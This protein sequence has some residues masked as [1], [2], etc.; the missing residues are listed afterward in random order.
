MRQLDDTHDLMPELQKAS[1]SESDDLDELRT[2]A[3][4]RRHTALKPDFALSWGPG[5]PHFP[6]AAFLSNTCRIWILPGAKT[7]ASTRR[8]TALDPDDALPWGPGVSHFPSTASCLKTVASV[9]RFASYRTS[10]TSGEYRILNKGPVAARDLSCDLK[11]GSIL[12]LLGTA[13]MAVAPETPLDQC[14]SHNL[15]RINGNMPGPYDAG[16]IWQ[17]HNDRFL[18]AGVWVPPD[19]DRSTPVGSAQPDG[20]APST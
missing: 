17:K 13:A 18:L 16:R 5:V 3:L 12:M 1:D 9:S 10:S 19:P 6:S 4:T 20:H 15:L 2:P 14:G 11:H 8:H 7:P